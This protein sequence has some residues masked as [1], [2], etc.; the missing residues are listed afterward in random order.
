MLENNFAENITSSDPS[1]MSPATSAITYFSVNNMFGDNVPNM[2]TSGSEINDTTISAV[3]SAANS[4]TVGL[5][6]PFDNFGYNAHNFTFDNYR[7]Y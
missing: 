5:D 4:P 6:L 1:Y 3:T 2:A 7:F